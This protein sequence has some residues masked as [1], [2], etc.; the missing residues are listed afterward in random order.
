MSAPPIGLVSDQ[1][2]LPAPDEEARLR[3]LLELLRARRSLIVLDNFET[4]LEPGAPEVGYRAGYEGYGQLLRW[5]GE[6]G[7]QSCLIVTSREVP[8]EVSPRAGLPWLPGVTFWQLTGAMVT[9][10][11]QPPG[12][13]HRYGETLA[14]DWARLLAEPAG[15]AARSSGQHDL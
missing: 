6:A 11:D 9:S 2:V 15:G 4:V 1:Q 8:P 5:L 14:D 10:L 13:G 12:H 7:H 3:Q